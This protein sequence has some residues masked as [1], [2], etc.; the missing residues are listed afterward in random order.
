MSYDFESADTKALRVILENSEIVKDIV[1]VFEKKLSDEEYV[2]KLPDF[3]G[4]CHCLS[5]DIET[6]VGYPRLGYEVVEILGWGWKHHTGNDVY[7]VPNTKGE[8]MWEGQQLEY[9]KSL[10][11]HIV[12]NLDKIDTWG[13]YL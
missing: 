12:D 10:M 2:S 13:E 5:K 8:W 7:P 1:V 3:A 9:R 6:A 4:I 11:Q